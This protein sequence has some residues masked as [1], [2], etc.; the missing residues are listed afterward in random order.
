MVYYDGF[1]PKA[2]VT[3]K[4]RFV[5]FNLALFSGTCIPLFMLSGGWALGV[6]FE[7]M[8][9]HLAFL[10]FSYYVHSVMYSSSDESPSPEKLMRMY[11]V[12]SVVLSILY[13]AFLYW[14]LF[15]DYSS[16]MALILPF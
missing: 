15:T 11:K 10:L 14:M 1:M 8:V 9:V 16:F 5:Y 13:A 3:P 6:I 4:Q 12:L 2:A 7:L